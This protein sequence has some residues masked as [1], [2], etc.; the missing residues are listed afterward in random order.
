MIY[1]LRIL[2]IFALVFLALDTSAQVGLD[3]NG[4]LHIYFG[5]KPRNMQDADSPGHYEL[6]TQLDKGE[7]DPGDSV[8]LSIFISGYGNI[9]ESKLVIEK[10]PAIFDIGSSYT[11]AINFE[12]VGKDKDGRDVGKVVYQRAGIPAPFVITL[13]GVKVRGWPRS[14]YYVDEE[15]TSHGAL[16]ILT[17]ST[18]PQAPFSVHF[19]TDRKIEPG[20]YNFAVIYTYFDGKEWVGEQQ[21]INFKVKS[22]V[23]RNNTWFTILGL[24]LAFIAVLPFL[25]DGVK[26]LVSYFSHIFRWIRNYLLANKRNSKAITL[27]K[28]APKKGQR[29]GP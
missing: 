12:L 4:Y 17:E 6:V 9:G 28:A 15:P 14:T 10:L 5:A 24:V 22:Y 1:K 8:T 3:Q 29:H 7:I 13:G 20:A 27:T 11:L 26:K 25:A 2:P 16:N 23:E 19:Q 18:F 21:T